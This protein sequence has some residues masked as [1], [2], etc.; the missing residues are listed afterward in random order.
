MLHMPLN[1]V[2]EGL[3]VVGIASVAA[4][5][6]A[7]LVQRTVPVA[8]RQ[9]NN[10]VAGLAFAIIGVLYAILLT[11]V[12][13]SVWE[14]NDTAQDSSRQEALAVV[15]LRRFAAAQADP[16]LRALT[17]QYVHLVAATEWPRMAKGEAVGPEGGATLDAMWKTVDDQ[18]PTDN[19]LV[20]R[21]AEARADLRAIGTARDARLA[22]VDAGLPRVMWLALVVGAGLTIVNAMMFG[23]HGSGEYLAIV[24]ML[25]AMSALILFAVYELEYPYQRLES[26]K[27]DTFTSVIGDVT[28]S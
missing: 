18:H 11:F 14:A 24:A 6:G 19:D 13:I 2:L 16:R 3:A 28:A 7:L 8:R 27:A 9:E 1:I 12:T 22:A 10:D 21:L 5:L 26:V 23:V 4:I 25:A 15:D 17:D 20:A